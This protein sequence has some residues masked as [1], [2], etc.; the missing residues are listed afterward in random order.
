MEMQAQIQAL[1]AAIEVE[2]AIE[3]SNIKVAKLPIFSGK[4]RNKAGF[5]TAYRLFLKMKI[6]KIAIEI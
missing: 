6:R 1:L 2:G 4:V 3:R 5:I